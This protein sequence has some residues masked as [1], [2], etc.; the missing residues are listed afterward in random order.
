[1]SEVRQAAIDL[2]TLTAGEVDLAMRAELEARHRARL[3][4]AGLEVAQAK[5]AL[6]SAEWDNAR[7]AL[8]A[9]RTRFGV[10]WPEIKRILG[11]GAPT[12][13]EHTRETEET[14][15]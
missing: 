6:A 1:V 14:Q 11:P 15:P 10:G 5:V 8:D 2:A 9:A 3:A 7:E 12:V 4:Q 13:T